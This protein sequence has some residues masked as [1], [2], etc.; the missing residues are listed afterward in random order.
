MSLDLPLAQLLS[1]STDAAAIEDTE[2]VCGA[3]R[4]VPLPERPF[5]DDLIAQAAQ[6]FGD[7]VAVVHREQGL[8]YRAFWHRVEAAEQ[9]LRTLGA[10]RATAVAIAL[11]PG[12]DRLV[13]V[14]ATLRTGACFV[15]LNPDHPA[16]R[17]RRQI[18]DC[19]DPLLVA[20]ANIARLLDVGTWV[21][22]GQTPPVEA[23]GI[24][25]DDRRGRDTAY[26]IHTSGSTGVPKA[27]AID[28]RAL[29]NRLTWMRDSLRVDEEDTILHRTAFGFDVSV[30]EQ[31]LPLMTGATIVIADGDDARDGNRLGALIERHRISI[32]HFVPTLLDAFLEPAV[33][34]RCGSLRAIVCSGE[35]LPRATALRCTQRLPAA[36]YNYYGPTEAAIDVT[37]WRFDPADPYDFVPIGRQIDNVDTYV[38]GSDGEPVAMGSV[39]ELYLGGVAVGNGY[40]GRGRQS[41]ERFVPDAFS[42]RP[43]ARLY[44]TGDFVRRHPG[45]VLEYIGRR[46]KQVK[47]RGFRIELGEIEAVV[48]HHPKI[49]Q[50]AIVLQAN[51]IASHLIAYV[52]TA[53]SVSLAAI[54]GEL[55]NF[56]ATALPPYMVPSAWVGL[57]RMPTTVNGKLDRDSLPRWEPPSAPIEQHSLL[58]ESEMRLATI[59]R[60]LLG[61]P[62]VAA[63]QN[64]FSLGGDS[65]LAIR[66]VA[67]ARGQG[68]LFEVADVFAHPTLRALASVM[69]HDVDT[70]PS[71]AIAPLPPVCPW[72][73]GF[74]R[75]D[76]VAV[77]FVWPYG[78]QSPETQAALSRVDTL[79]GMLAGVPHAGWYV[80]MPGTEPAAALD[81]LAARLTDKPARSFAAAT[82]GN[83]DDARL[84]LVCSPTLIDWE[85]VARLADVIAGDDPERIARAYQDWARTAAKL[86]APDSARGAIRRIERADRNEATADVEVHA[87]AISLDGNGE[88]RVP[89][90]DVV[91]DLVVGAV[92]TGLA[93]AGVDAAQCHVSDGR[94]WARDAGWAVSPL[95]GRLAFEHVLT[96]KLSDWHGSDQELRALHLARIGQTPL[97]TENQPDSVLCHF[98]IV[99]ARDIVQAV[100]ESAARADSSRPAIA[101]EFPASVVRS[102]ANAENLWVVATVH[103]D[104]VSLALGGAALQGRVDCVQTV[105][106]TFA[107]LCMRDPAL[108]TAADLPEIAAATPSRLP[109]RAPLADAYDVYRLAPMQ[110]GMLLRARF[111]PDSD[112]YLNQNLIE[113]RGPLD[114]H[115]L[116]R[117][118]MHVVEHYEALRTG[119][120]S[121]GLDR[122]V[123]YVAPRV[124]EGIVE[125]DWT[126]MAS[127]DEPSLNARLDAFL[128]ED[129]ARRFDLHKAGLWRFLLI[130]VASD[131]HFI[132]W[133]HH[134]LL[135]DGWCLSL[136]WGDTFRCYASNVE[137]RPHGL[138]R[139]RPF[140][141]YLAWLAERSTGDADRQFWRQH[142]DGFATPTLFSRFGQDREGRFSTRRIVL[143]AQQTDALGALARETEVTVN[144]VI[145]S[146]WS[147][148]LGARTGTLD[149][150]HG[151]AVSGRPP[152]LDGADTMV[153]LFI[154]TIPLRVRHRAS[155][156]VAA[157]LRQTQKALAEAALHAH[158]PLSE[159]VGQWRG[160]KRGEDRLFDSLIAFENYPEDNLP[161]GD[162]CGLR[163]IDR[164]CDEKTEYPFGLI[165]LPGRELELHFNYDTAHFDDAEIGAFIAHYRA[166]LAA[167]VD[168][169]QAPLATLPA[170]AAAAS[171]VTIVSATARDQV[172][173]PLEPAASL[174][175]LIAEHGCL[176]PQRIAIVDDERE[177]TY[178]DLERTIRHVAR[179]W[180]RAGVCAGDVVLLQMRRSRQLV[181]ALLAIWRIGAT[182]AVLN[183]AHPRALIRSCAMTAGARHIS[184][185]IDHGSQAEDR[186]DLPGVSV[187]DWPSL[188]DGDDAPPAPAADCGRFMLFTSGS[189]G[190]PK[191]VSCIERGLVA[192]IRTTAAL[193]S[194]DHG[195]R[196]VLLANAAP[197]FDIGLWEFFYPL[198]S[199]G[200][201]VVAN[202]A[203]T[204]DPLRLSRAIERHRIGVLHLIPS[205]LDLLLQVAD[206]SAL[207]SLRCV[208]T[209]GET[210]SP[211]TLRRFFSAG[212]MASLWQ[213]YGPTE[214]SVSVTDRRC[215]PGDAEHA[216][217]PL[218]RASGGALLH[219]LDDW[220]R[221]VADG[222][223]GELYIAGDG[224][225]E[226][227]V[228]NP[229]ATALARLPDPWGP[230]GAVMYRSG[231]RAIRRLDGQLEF[232]GRAD[233]QVKLNGRRIDLDMI[234]HLFRRHPA[235]REAAVVLAGP[236]RSS[237]HLHVSLRDDALGANGD[238]IRAWSATALP[239]GLRLPVTIHGALPINANRKLDR[240]ALLRF[241]E[242]VAMPLLD[243]GT[244][245]VLDE[246]P[247]ANVSSNSLEAGIAQ[248]WHDVLGR[249][250][251]SRDESF[252]EAG[253][254]SLAAMKLVLA[255][256]Q[257][258][259]ANTHVE[260]SHVFK[261][262]SIA[263]MAEAMLAPYEGSG[264]DHI[265]D[266]AMP[267]A[268]SR[269]PLFLI[270]PV[271]GLSLCY[272]GIDRWIPNRRIVAFNNPRQFADAKF[273]TLTEMAQ[274]Y[275]EWV[276]GI[277]DDV[278]VALG[279]WSFGGVVALE[280]ARQMRAHG[281]DATKVV[282]IDSYNLCGCDP[283]DTYRRM[284]EIETDVELAQSLRKE[285][286]HNT[287]LSLS[288]TPPAFDGNV[289][290][291][292]AQ[293]G[294]VPELGPCNGWS[295]QR[296]PKLRVCPVAGD[297]NQLFGR[298]LA[299]TAIAIASALDERTDWR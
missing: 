189:T 181:A 39:G 186:A 105:M 139:P 274:L 81:E 18:A 22:L 212:L 240:Q 74:A 203:E 136:I 86:P 120:L 268:A 161:H 225:F 170:R 102:F 123:Q 91:P 280:M 171:P 134:H 71:V 258:L 84:L 247:Q 79:F 37:A 261:F 178:A 160:R 64:F 289:V 159:I 73:R 68:C 190:M 281:G 233:R 192:R 262:P 215:E 166:L 257:R 168:T 241:H 51:G 52:V 154:N 155:D 277:A 47:V 138:K 35:A 208:I 17:L 267:D 107:Q 122:P 254:H 132:V 45:G 256:R 124:E 183:P 145:Q 78:M 207:A 40:L 185:T 21:V 75:G 201:V 14:V 121:D 214:A 16:E 200:T 70:H 202:D 49:R 135:L 65:I 169:P 31:L 127:A 184:T 42:D 119:Y 101:P 100:G 222:V 218:G 149:V 228:G 249:P 252:F 234:E 92:L 140:R 11:A 163:I 85:S 195:E 13:A 293:D 147:L 103:R 93:R 235:I 116:A 276:R 99:D 165:V 69:R 156:S 23:A 113:L 299:T 199:G 283:G 44:R 244:R 182:P 290:L 131:R 227:Y 205:L 162:I 53:A 278:P 9:L 298:H 46:D 27:C 243:A 141:D 96:M 175:R 61:V 10:Q 2:L 193:Y 232:R 174:D 206:P 89:T 292:Q 98:V 151:V 191:A 152:Q 291:L 29:Y 20:D 6:R 263:T 24:R 115:S 288:A 179:S 66:A 220:L 55:R 3:G 143:S 94:R 238:A 87:H 273:S 294:R 211:N 272:R 125:I 265:I 148:M 216:R 5:V 54:E 248:A 142:L 209:G 95:I 110:E 62:D 63:D 270:H 297:H 264:R 286:A 8:D 112:A 213:G 255:I 26:V 250:P 12:I 229:K 295:G 260:V 172:R 1:D 269:E 180:R 173:S 223:E 43:D 164:Q 282:M 7:R 57:D 67:R 287:Y 210:L 285:I 118:W 198:T 56:V 196:P 60:D 146:A 59:W 77:T 217:V 231:D 266:V 104:R 188:D 271:E 246:T 38:L 114:R 4:H 108:R 80:A 129:R 109:L 167:F 284:P 187:L 157:L 72:S 236:S 204:A 83:P 58:S 226:G 48:R 176:T 245:S 230:A 177:W 197:G 41:A 30:W 117:A 253:G 251:R 88:Y 28:H 32:C 111:W 275:V 82:C 194:G 144:T 25:R 296:W 76:V 90:A 242:P 237:L 50:V 126:H 221:P 36:V 150:V 239:Y 19:G 33:P 130:R 219:V 224:L 153:G 259:P 133:S 15:P 137:G 106:E 97:A 34:E 279:G 158:V 128:D